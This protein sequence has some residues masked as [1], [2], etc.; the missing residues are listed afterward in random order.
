MFHFNFIL[1]LSWVNFWGVTLADGL[2]NLTIIFFEIL[3]ITLKQKEKEK[4]ILYMK[5]YYMQK[6][7]VVH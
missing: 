5:V 7:T 3:L 2:V 6:K 4:Q 1:V